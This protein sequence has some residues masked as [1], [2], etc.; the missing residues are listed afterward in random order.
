MK[1]E[2]IVFMIVS[3]LFGVVVGYVITKAAYKNR[4]SNAGIEAVEEVPNQAKEDAGGL[5]LPPG[6]PDISK[7]YQK[8]IETKLKEVENA[9]SDI[10]KINELAF[11]YEQMRRYG[12]ALKWYN[13]ALELNGDNIDA[14]NGAATIYRLNNEINKAKELYNKVL[15]INK[16]DVN[17]LLGLGWIA[18]HVDNDPKEAARLWQLLIDNNPDFIYKEELQAEIN[19]INKK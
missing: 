5:S 14:L 6:H 2:F 7:D 18:L 12:D 17:A 1:K 16:Y 9:P 4:L 11:L 10:N 3:F 19:K 13:R 15:K 8:E